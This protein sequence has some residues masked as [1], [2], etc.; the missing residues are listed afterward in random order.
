MVAVADGA[1]ALWRCEDMR[2]LKIADVPQHET[3]MLTRNLREDAVPKFS[4]RIFSDQN[5]AS[6]EL[7]AGSK[8]PATVVERKQKKPRNTTPGA[9][10][11][12]GAKQRAET[13]MG[14]FNNSLRKKCGDSSTGLNVLNSVVNDGVC[15]GNCRHE[16]THAFDTADEC[17]EAVEEL[18]VA[19]VSMLNDERLD[20]LRAIAG[21][22]P[23]TRN[24][25]SVFGRKCC[26]SHLMWVHGHSVHHYNILKSGRRRIGGQRVA[27]QTGQGGATAAGALTKRDAVENW[28]EKAIE[29][30]GCKSPSKRNVVYMH[31]I[32]LS[33][34]LWRLIKRDFTEDG[35]LSL[36]PSRSHYKKIWYQNYGRKN[37]KK[38]GNPD[39]RLRKDVEVSKCKVCQNLQLKIARG[40]KGPQRVAA[41]RELDNHVLFVR[42][43]REAYS[44]NRLKACCGEALSAGVDAISCFGTTQP[45]DPRNMGAIHEWSRTKQKVTMCVLHGSRG[46]REFCARVATPAWLEANGNLQQTIFM[47]VILQEIINGW[48]EKHPGR[49]L[50][51]TL[52]IQT[53]RGSD[54]WNKT[55]FAL[56]SWIVE[57]KKYFTKIVVSA[58]P[59]GHSHSDYDRV[60]AAFIH[61][62]KRAPGEGSLSTADL[63][64]KLERMS[65]SIGREVKDTYDFQEW[66]AP[67]I[68]KKLHHHTKALKWSFE[69]NDHGQAIASFAGDC[70]STAEIVEWGRILI[71]KP[72]A[73]G[74]ATCKRWVSAQ[75]QEEWEASVRKNIGLIESMEEHHLSAYGYNG[76]GAKDKAKQEWVDYQ[77]E[78]Q[79]EAILKPWPPPALIE[80]VDIGVT[81]LEINDALEASAG[82]H[83]MQ[84][85]PPQIQPLQRQGGAAAGT[86]PP[87][88]IQPPQSQGVNRVCSAVEWSAAVE[89]ADIEHRLTVGR[90]YVVLA[91]DKPKVWLGKVT[92]FPSRA[93][94]KA[95]LMGIHGAKHSQTRCL[96]EKSTLE[97]HNT[98]VRIRWYACP[99][100]ETTEWDEL[101]QVC[102]EGVAPTHLPPF[103]LALHQP[104]HHGGGLDYVDA[105]QIGPEMLLHGNGRLKSSSQRVL[106]AA[107]LKLRAQLHA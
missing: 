103:S 75:Q 12:G 102:S 63:I 27:R 13:A 32:S 96:E 104:V 47:D 23:N 66:L 59:V 81:G 69:L 64:G 101:A 14:C 77:N 1:A 83:G 100:T 45:I 28:F 7:G 11:K 57:E 3:D 68:N 20:H 8:R 85:P 74:P 78:G 9:A 52:F 87:P 44:A 18:R 91:H 79:S 24:T 21:E 76:V 37:W 62:V 30:I 48:K 82:T 26:L 36:L 22:T 15:S 5:E 19:R 33:G 107:V 38:K 40:Q 95:G 56:M 55:F 42:R 72:I 17:H 43:Q 51:S 98:A 106:A 2:P 94:R 60:G 29:D 70:S 34:D 6:N 31:G 10:N 105:T 39:V 61:F 80:I 65:N 16:M 53:D 46:H 88:Q 67:H 41:Q 86:Q 4:P 92:S 49:R 25:Y 54:M 93:P 73:G 35:M 71:S 97:K 89:N 84:P 50:P 90:T 99:N 58:L